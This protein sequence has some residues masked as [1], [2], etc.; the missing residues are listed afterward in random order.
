VAGRLGAARDREA[1][2]PALVRL[3]TSGEGGS[4]AA[5]RDRVGGAVSGDLGVATRR[6]REVC[7]EA[8]PRA[9]VAGPEPGTP[10]PRRR[11]D[12]PPPGPPAAWGRGGG[13]AGGRSKHPDCGGVLVPR[14]CA[15]EPAAH[16]TGRGADRWEEGG[17]RRREVCCRRWKGRRGCRGC[18]RGGGGELRAAGGRAGRRRLQGGR[19]P[20]QPGGCGWEGREKEKFW[21]W[22]QVGMG[23]PNPNQ[24]WV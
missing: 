5:A 13:G 10:R 20:E 24:G 15:V 7:Q 17:G 18:S 4:A 19:R 12:A 14:L 8:A 22:Y 11:G 9:A 23:N 6:G 1:E 16:R 21:L 3:R 2:E